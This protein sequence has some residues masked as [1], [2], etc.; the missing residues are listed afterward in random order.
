MHIQSQRF[1]AV[2]LA[3]DAILNF[4]TG[5]I[6]FPLE[7]T[8]ALIPHHGSSYLG[9]LQSTTRPEL[10]FPVVSA[11]AFGDSYPEIAVSELACAAGVGD[12]VGEYALLVVLSAPRGQQATVNL[13]APIVVN[14][15]TRSGAQ[16]ILEGSRFSTREPFVL[17]QT[18]GR[19]V[20]EQPPTAL[21]AAG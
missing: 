2:E 6:G 5:I 15:E 1:G 19:S 3:E 8:F 12:S 4:P 18:L 10:A 11:H 14:A 16:V 17:P 7:R 20:P 21:C 13:L 9:W